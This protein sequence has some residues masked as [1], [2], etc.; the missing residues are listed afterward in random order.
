MLFILL[1][2]LII[3]INSISADEEDDVEKAYQ[4]LQNEIAARGCAAMSVEEKAFSIL[5]LPNFD[6]CIANLKTDTKTT[7]KQK[8]LSLMALKSAG[9]NTTQLE[10]DLLNQKIVPQGIDWYLQV[11]LDGN[12]SCEA[13][14]DNTIYPFSIGANKKLSA[15]NGRAGNCLTIS[16]EKGNYWFLIS[17]NCYEKTFE[18]GCDGSGP[19]LTN[20]LYQDQNSNTIFVSDKTNTAGRGTSGKTTEKI[21]SYCFRQSP[22]SPACDYE[23][24]L[25]AALALDLSGK[26]VDSFVDYLRAKAESNTQVFSAPI[27]YYLTEYQEYYTIISNSQGRFTNNRFWTVSGD[28]A[29]DTALAL[30]PFRGTSFPGKDDAKTS[31][32]DIRDNNG[33]W[34]ESSTRKIRNTAFVL[35][36]IWPEFDPD[37]PA[38]SAT[39]PCPTGFSCQNNQC[40]Q[41]QQNTTCPAVPCQTGYTC[42]SGQCVQNQQTGCTTNAQCVSAHGQGWICNLQTNEC[43]EEDN[44]CQGDTQCTDDDLPRCITGECKECRPATEDVDCGEE[45]RCINNICEDRDDV[46]VPRCGDGIIYPHPNGFIEQCDGTNLQ[47]TSCTTQGFDGGNLSCNSN[48]TLNISLCYNDPED[49]CS[50]D[51]DCT[52]ANSTCEDGH[53]VPPNSINESVCGNGILETGEACDRSLLRNL[54]TCADLSQFDGGNLTCNI[55]NSTNECQFNTTLCFVNDVCV[56]DEDCE[57]EGTGYECV[58]GVCLPPIVDECDDDDECDDNEICDYGECKPRSTGELPDC[59]DDFGYYCRSTNACLNDNG[60]LLDQYSCSSLGVCC[61]RDAVASTCADQSGVICNSNQRCSGGTEVMNAEDLSVGE[62]C[63]IG[64]FCDD[65]SDETSDCEWYGGSCKVSCSSGETQNSDDCEDVYG[66]GYICCVSETVPPTPSKPSYVWLWILLVLIVL[67]VVAILFRDKLR[68]AFMK[69]RSKFG[70]G[71]QRRPPGFPPPP[72]MMSRPIPRR[73]LP[74][75]QQPRPMPP[76]PPASGIPPRP[77]QQKPA[78]SRPA[79]KPETKKEEKPK[80]DLDDVLKKL[81]EMGK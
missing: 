58:Y 17:P 25:W 14:Y 68:I 37:A 29:Y 59:E 80:S 67:V 27:L 47:F 15:N 28:K 74:P 70:K 52:G 41:N 31:L 72:G 9:E 50:D 56:E 43:I 18:I 81:K 4:C 73:I 33:C 76:R 8:A 12:A 45:Q 48:C 26:D 11:E 1:L 53:C 6:P 62:I 10:N 49:Q 19:F 77:I 35:Y 54:T 20:L 65:K 16:S 78:P 13:F 24:S 32:L 71:E 51:D 55:A 60:E 75:G 42:Q 66:D 40:V 57:D 5:A 79:Q 38:C 69:L 23:G 7:I 36:S 63:C 22:T 2:T 44:S 64:G 46:V 30:L 34:P 39:N 61:S 21:N 3:S